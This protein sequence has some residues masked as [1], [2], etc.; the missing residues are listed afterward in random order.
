MTDQNLD[1]QKVEQL[2]ASLRD[3]GVTGV[4]ITWADNNGIPRGRIVP[5]DSLPSVSRRGVGVTVL[6]A[7]FDSHDAI[8]H[9]YA[10]LGNASGDRR[11]V[12]V[13]DRIRPLAGQ[14][15][16]AWAPGVQ[17]TADGTRS[18]YDQRAALEAQVARA[19]E[20]DFEIR[21]GYEI[22]FT[23]YRDGAPG[24]AGPAYSP[25]AI[26]QLD[27]LVAAILHDFAANGLRINQLHTEFG[28]AQVELSLVATNPLS[29]ADDQLL[30]RQTLHAA[31]SHLGYRLSFAPLT[32][33]AGVGNGWHVHT[34]V[35]RDGQNLLS[36][37]GDSTDVHGLGADGSAYV[38]G[39]LE[40]LPAISAISAPSVPSRVRIRPGYFAGA[41]AFWG[42]ENREA[43]LRVAQGGE[44]V[45][46]DYWNLELKVSDASAN[47]Y[48]T[49]AAL[50]G[51]GVDGIERSA[52]LPEPIADDP[53]TWTD[54]QRE[55]RGIDLLPQTSAH[56]REALAHDAFITSLFTPEQTG[57]FDA[58]RRSDEA[59]AEGKTDD[60][61][62]AGHRWLY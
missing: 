5:I 12:P 27:D 3:Q 20:H 51:A 47:P 55:E 36:P 59:W 28:Q 39:V 58:V 30:A 45:G 11:L 32:E 56:A 25:H 43:T 23:V 33:A 22:E 7:V 38:A 46:A 19:A 10:G 13:L 9:D 4:W 24:H 26:I 14:P 34:S 21:A 15:G 29:A 52:A 6:F 61:V 40:H 16:L 62:V 53:G 48:L 50:I 35:W 17:F 2:T 49:L 54:A 42:V 60:E 37:A 44:L 41:Y 18:E 31:A 8:T 57:A 1:A